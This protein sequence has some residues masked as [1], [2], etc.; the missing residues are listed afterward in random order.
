LGIGMSLKSYVEG[1]LGL[2]G[3]WLSFWKYLIAELRLKVNFASWLKGCS[4]VKYTFCA[5]FGEENHRHIYKQKLV[6]HSTSW[7]HSWQRKINVLKSRPWPTLPI[8]FSRQ[9]WQQGANYDASWDTTI[10]LL[11]KVFSGGSEVS[12]L[13]VLI[14][15]VDVERAGLAHAG[16]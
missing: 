4:I 3:Q 1:C 6:F 16:F 2:K 7:T 10:A 15:N 13:V 8:D 11:I 12:G 14:A 9:S 5:G